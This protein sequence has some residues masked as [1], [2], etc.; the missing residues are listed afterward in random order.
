MANEPS[1]KIM[2]TLVKHDI[3]RKPKTA[4]QMRDEREKKEAGPEEAKKFFDSLIAEGQKPPG[5]NK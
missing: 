2:P 3:R 1:N 5:L 4:A